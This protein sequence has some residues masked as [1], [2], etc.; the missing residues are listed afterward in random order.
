[1]SLK[2]QL[3]ELAKVTTFKKKKGRGV[4]INNGT[5][6]VDVN[7]NATCTCDG[8]WN[9]TYCQGNYHS[10]EIS[11]EIRGSRGCDRMV[12]GFTSPLS[13]IFQLYP[14]GQFYWWRKPESPE[15]TTNLSQDTDKLSSHNVV[16]ST[17]RYQRVLN[18]QLC[19][20]IFV[21]VENA[22]Q[23]SEL[24]CF[25]FP[26]SPCVNN[27]C[28]NNGTCSVD[29]NGNATCTCDETTNL[30]QNTDKLLSHNV[31]LSTPLYERVSNSQL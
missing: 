31:V 29:V 15:K 24:K 25:L 12:V 16:L 6:S 19:T 11:K 10:N 30:S 23:F 20:E 4:S 26:V 9:G 2:I 27:P 17:H 13:T 21:N 18:S 22:L 3:I 14:G 28:E 8:N 7:G 5:C 1:L